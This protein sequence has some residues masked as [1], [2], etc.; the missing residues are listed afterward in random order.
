MH[1]PLIKTGISV[2][3]S[4]SFVPPAVASVSFTCRLFFFSCRRQKK[5]H[6]LSHCVF[7]APRTR[8][9]TVKPSL[10]AL[11]PS[12]PRDV[13]P[14]SSPFGRSL[15]PASPSGGSDFRFRSFF[16][17]LSPRFWV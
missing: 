12:R 16:F 4:S 15:P 7:G 3:A 8:F 2:K 9:E 14:V 6:Y 17:I 10:P 11:F 5:Q 13:T 1:L